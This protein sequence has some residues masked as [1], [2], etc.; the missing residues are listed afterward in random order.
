[1]KLTDQVMKIV[2]KV[3]KKLMREQVVIDGLQFSLKCQDWVRIVTSHFA[4]CEVNL[5]IAIVK[6]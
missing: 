3:N 2:E 4:N 5:V 1:M 6:L